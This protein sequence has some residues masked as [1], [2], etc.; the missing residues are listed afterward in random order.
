MIVTKERKLA[1]FL[2]QE[3]ANPDE[4][5]PNFDPIIQRRIQILAVPLPSSYTSH[6]GKTV[7]YILVVLHVACCLSMVCI[8]RSS[9]H[10]FCFRSLAC[11]ERTA[12]GW[13]GRLT[14]N[15]DFGDSDT[16]VS[17]ICLRQS[18]FGYHPKDGKVYTMASAIT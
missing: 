11:I 7:R 10:S 4:A 15:E 13:D 5:A 3:P 17:S 14:A 16:F 6:I 8:L 12:G 18:S 1:C 2:Q 9:Q